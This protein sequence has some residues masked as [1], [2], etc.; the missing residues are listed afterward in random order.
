MKLSLKLPLLYSLTLIT[1]VTGCKTLPITDTATDN[2]WIKVELYFGSEVPGIDEHSNIGPYNSIE[3]VTNEEWKEFLTDVV[4]PRFQYGFSM[5][6]GI[7][8]WDRNGELILEK[9]RK[10][11][12]VFDPLYK[13]EAIT[14]I[15]EIIDTYKEQF[16]QDSVMQ[17]IYRIQVDFK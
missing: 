15:N 8:G 12:F 2:S 6:E 14:Y 17:V 11:I 3:D 16:N 13:G 4:V 5:F 10:L 7:G 9:S 1:I